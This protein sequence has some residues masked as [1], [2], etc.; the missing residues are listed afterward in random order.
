MPLPQRAP[1][2][3]S[4]YLRR[5]GITRLPMYLCNR[6][7]RAIT[8]VELFGTG[9]TTKLQDEVTVSATSR[10]RLN[11]L[12]PGCCGLIDEYDLMLDGDNLLAF[13]ASYTDADGVRR[14][15]SALLGT[16][17]GAGSLIRLDV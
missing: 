11:R 2:G 4:L 17:V 6:T 1:E 3:F 13:V 5:R 8:D 10:R 14:R 15:L 9:V 7:D 12:E 16:D